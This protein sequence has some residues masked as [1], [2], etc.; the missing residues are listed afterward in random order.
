V[1]SA[2]LAAARAVVR[3][4]GGD[5]LAERLEHLDARHAEPNRPV[6]E[7]RAPDRNAQ[8]DFDVALAGGGL[9]LLLVPLLRRAGLKVAVL[10]RGEIGVSHREWNASGAE[11]EVLIRTGLLS[12]EVLD[13]LVLNRYRDGF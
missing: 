8:A 1:T 13:T 7:S 4:C 3:D 2:A 9:S 5:E 11:L 12:P 10:D 6:S